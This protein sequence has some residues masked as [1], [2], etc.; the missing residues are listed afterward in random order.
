MKD[1][2]SAGRFLVQFGDGQL[3]VIRR[4][5]NVSSYG[6]IKGIMGSQVVDSL[7]LRVRCECIIQTCEE[8]IE[9]SLG[10]RRELRRAYPRG[11][12]T[13]TAHAS[14]SEDNILC[15]AERYSVIAM[16]QFTESVTDL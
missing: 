4:T 6:V 10:E 16:P 9:V 15:V 5:G 11:F 14:A 8:I 1:R 7:P 13:V 3:A 12:I 2:I